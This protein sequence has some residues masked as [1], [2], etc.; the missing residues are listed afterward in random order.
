MHDICHNT[1]DDNYDFWQNKCKRRLIIHDTATYQVYNYSVV[2]SPDVMPAGHHLA[3]QDT[4]SGVRDPFAWI[5]VALP[6]SA[7]TDVILLCSASASSLLVIIY[8]RKCANAFALDVLHRL[9][10][11]FGMTP[12]SGW[13]VSRHVRHPLDF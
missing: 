3:T 6:T 8:V 9:R 11:T 7:F 2:S 5:E 1:F 10:S 12:M 13:S 4:H